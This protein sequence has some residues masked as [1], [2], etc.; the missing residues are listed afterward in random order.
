[1]PKAIRATKQAQSIVIVLD[2]FLLLY[3][4]SLDSQPMLHIIPKDALFSAATLLTREGSVDE[5]NNY[6]STW[7]NQYVGH[8]ESIHA[9]F[10]PQFRSV[11]WKNY[12]K[13]C[14][15]SRQS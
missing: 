3:L 8:P 9:D 15:I 10:C 12:L 13:T 6:M 11:M 2:R 1:M 7:V 5:W 14:D 4:M